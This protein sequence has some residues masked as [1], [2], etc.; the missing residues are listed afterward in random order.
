MPGPHHNSQAYEDRQWD[1]AMRQ[2]SQ[3][4]RHDQDYL[5]EMALKR[6]EKEEREKLTDQ[7]QTQTSEPTPD[8]PTH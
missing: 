5:L 1:I 3:I 2:L 4:D 6:K 7:T 8:E